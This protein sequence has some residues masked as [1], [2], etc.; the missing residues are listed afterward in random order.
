MSVFQYPSFFRKVRT[1]LFVDHQERDR[2]PFP[3][4]KSKGKVE[5]VPEQSWTKEPVSN[6][7]P[8]HKEK[9]GLIPCESGF[10]FPFHGGLQNDDR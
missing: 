6:P 3:V 9:E 5:D 10:S 8:N 4:T 7:L 2:E 1:F